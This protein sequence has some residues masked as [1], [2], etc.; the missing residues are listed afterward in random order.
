M[1]I[2]F[3]E[4]SINIYA[5]QPGNQ[6]WADEIN[7]NSIYWLYVVLAEMPLLPLYRGP[8]ESEKGA[9]SPS[10]LPDS[11][12]LLN[13]ELAFNHLGPGINVTAFQK[14]YAC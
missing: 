9:S 1:C 7:V 8:D 5:A 11:L 6:R 3:L 12:Q 14:T 4:Q 10:I 2:L 13:A